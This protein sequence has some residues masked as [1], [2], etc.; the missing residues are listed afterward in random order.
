MA[1]CPEFSAWQ[2]ALSSITTTTATASTT[3]TATTAT[4]A[5]P[6]CHRSLLTGSG[7]SLS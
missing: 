7:A 4:T 5:V 3:A 2:L 6:H 1:R